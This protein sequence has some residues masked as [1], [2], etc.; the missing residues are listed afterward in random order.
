MARGAPSP[1]ESRGRCESDGLDVGHLSRRG[2]SERRQGDPATQWA[3]RLTNQQE[4]AILGTLA[5]AYAEA[6]RFS[7]AVETAKRALALATRHDRTELL[8]ALRTQ[9]KSYKAG[10]PYREPAEHVVRPKP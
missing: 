4:P 9:L 2:D 10:K 1:A 7:E 8:D 3:V 6:G 5:A